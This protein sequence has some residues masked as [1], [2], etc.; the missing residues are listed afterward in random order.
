MQSLRYKVSEVKV[1]TFPHRVG[2]NYH[3]RSHLL[4][5]FALRLQFNTYTCMYMKWTFGKN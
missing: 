2:A 5:L 3:A 4:F 1:T